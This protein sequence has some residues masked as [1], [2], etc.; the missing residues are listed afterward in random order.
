MPKDLLLNASLPVPPAGRG[1]V[2][3]LREL[4][5]GPIGK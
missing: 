5:P 4:S 3:A 2:D 1:L